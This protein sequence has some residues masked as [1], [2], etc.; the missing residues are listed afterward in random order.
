MQSAFLKKLTKDTWILR[1]NFF[2]KNSSDQ[3]ESMI[4]AFVTVEVNP[5]KLKDNILH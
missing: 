2:L 4:G 5:W 3:D 1:S